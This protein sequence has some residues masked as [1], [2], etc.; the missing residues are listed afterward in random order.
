MKKD[1]IDRKLLTTAARLSAQ[2]LILVVLSF[3]GLYAGIYLDG[4]FNI[5][6]NMTF[7]FLMIG[8]SAGFF[9]FIRESKKL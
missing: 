2:G 1:K 8:I 9:G 6:P 7:L 4:I 3:L 5:A